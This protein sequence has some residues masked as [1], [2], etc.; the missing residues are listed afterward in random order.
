VVYAA[1]DVSASTKDLT[2]DFIGYIMAL[3]QFE[4]V[5]FFD[6]E[7]QY[8]LKKGQSM[9]SVMNGYGGTDINCVIKRWQKIEDNNKSKKLNFVA[10]TDGY[11]EEIEEMTKEQI[12]VL[13]TGIDIEGARNIRIRV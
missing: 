3:P 9:P 13:T 11:V 2:E 4:E 7:I 12:L 5:V 8:V 10:L 6:T 1:V